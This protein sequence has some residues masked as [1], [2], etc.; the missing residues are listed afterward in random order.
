MEKTHV[1]NKGQIV[2]AKSE[3]EKELMETKHKECQGK[4]PY[5]G[6]E[7]I[8][9]EEPTR[10]GDTISY[11]AR[12]ADCGETFDEDY[13]VEYAETSYLEPKEKS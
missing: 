11:P 6:S 9:Y 8:D 12:C 1:N 3:A 5:C 4:C 10:N 7:N 2:F 13:A